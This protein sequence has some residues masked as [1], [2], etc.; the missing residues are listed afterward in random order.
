MS[1]LLASDHVIVV[2]AGLAGWRFVESLRR[3]GF[4]GDV[5][6]VGEEPH[7][8]Y[9][10]PPLSKQVMSGKWDLAKATLAS[11]EQ[12]SESGAT[13]RLGVR[14]T[15][16]D[17]ATTTV[18]LSDGSS[19]VGTHV[20]VAT[21]SR[22]RQLSFPSTGS[23]PTLR[24]HD[25]A[26]R[27]TTVLDALASE[28]VVVVIGG[29]F[30][31]A[32]VATSLKTR[33]LT[34]VVLEAM[35][36]PLIAVVGEQASSWL[37]ALGED[38]G[39]EVRTNQRVSDVREIDDGFIVELS[40]GSSIEARLV[41]AAVGSS[42]D[43]A[44]LESSGLILD[45]GVVVDRDLQ[46]DLRVAAIGDVARHRW[47]GAAG[48][49]VVRIEHWQVATDH[50]A[51]LAHFWMTGERSAPMVPYFWSDQYGKKIQMLGHPHPDDDVLIVSGSTEEK[52]WLALY[53]RRDVVTGALALS[54]PRWLMLSKPLL[55]TRTS[56][57]DA[58]TSAP[59]LS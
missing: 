43:L 28:S 27:L 35:E 15:E 36:R 59:W 48:E 22:A 11:P 23:L 2:G 1:T 24:N 33:G 57:A 17:V 9:D 44:W 46:A 56:L 40:D 55:D 53:S 58:L 3:E 52:K 39:V 29:G 5:T 34:P 38:A 32:E 51:H 6:L 45:N 8:P 42:L 4:E 19:V 7:A 30:V 41:I 14:A 10:R 50:A 54:Q 49:E 47:L 21:G 37:G 31:G 12:L 25:D 18:H 16:L 13:L 20:V 26:V